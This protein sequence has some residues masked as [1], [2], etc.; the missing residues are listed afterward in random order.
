[1]NVRWAENTSEDRSV[2]SVITKP[3]NYCAATVEG[4]TT[5]LLLDKQFEED[6]DEERYRTIGHGMKHFVQQPDGRRTD[7]PLCATVVAHTQRYDMLD[8]PWR[9]LAGVKRGKPRTAVSSLA[10]RL[11]SGEDVTGLRRTARV[12]RLNVLAD[13]QLYYLD[14]REPL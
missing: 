2:W 6:E 10:A 5:L 7:Q 14:L 13:A 4:R 11:P 1:M 8:K 3:I 9:A 12:A